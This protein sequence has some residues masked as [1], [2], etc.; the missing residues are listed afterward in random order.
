MKKI[1]R[2]AILLGILVTTAMG[3]SA[4]TIADLPARLQEALRRDSAC[5]KTAHTVSTDAPQFLHTPIVTQPILGPKGKEVG[6]VVA[7]QG[8]CH[9]KG[10]NCA[11]FVYLKSGLAYKLAFSHIFSSLHQM[12]AFNGGFP[13]LSGKLEVDESR[14]ETRVYDWTGRDYQAK[15]CATITQ[16]TGQKRPTIVRHACGS[17]P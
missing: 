13:S 3:Q 5:E 7:P 6:L 16:S 11:T 12:K 4:E 8:G 14:A 10:A 9:C 1:E 2:T 17:T 15:L